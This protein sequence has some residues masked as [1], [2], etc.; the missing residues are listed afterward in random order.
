MVESNSMWS[1]LCQFYYRL[2]LTEIFSTTCGVQNLLCSDLPWQVTLL[3]LQ[4]T[5]LPLQVTLLPLQVTL[6]PLQVT[7]L[8]IQVTLLPLQVTLL[9]FKSHFYPFKSHYYLQFTL[10]PLQ[11]TLLPLQVT[12]LPLQVTLLPLQV[13]QITMMC[14]FQLSIVFHFIWPWNKFLLVIKWNQNTTLLPLSYLYINSLFI[15]I[16]CS[17]IQ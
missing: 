7:L 11:F 16:A 2:V 6:L 12:L 9:P 17:K 15:T 1:I 8:P 10:L 3:P 13:I 14:C 4:V 5:H